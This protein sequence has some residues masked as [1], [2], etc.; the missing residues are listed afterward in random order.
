M[1]KLVSLFILLPFI[2]FSQPMK[3][4]NE[5]EIKLELQKLNTVGSVLYIAAH[6][7]DENTRLLSYLANE[8]KV[9]TA[10]LSL[11][12][13]DGGQNLIGTEQGELLGM[14][15][16]Q[17]LLEA[18]KLDGA[19]QFFTR[20][21]DF[22]FSKNPDETFEKWNKEKI[23]EDVVYIIRKFKPDVI[24]TRFPTTGEGGHGHHTAS[25]ILAVEA[26]DAAADA[27]RFP[28]QVKQ[29]GVWQ[30]KRLVW[31]T[32][33]FS[34]RSTIDSTQLK[35]SIN[36]YNPLLGKSYGELAAEGRTMH[37]SQ[38][39]GSAKN[40][41]Q[42]FEYF[43]HL[44]G[45]EA[46]TDVLEGVNT[47]WSAYQDAKELSNTLAKAYTSYLNGND[48]ETTNNLLLAL[49]QLKN[50]KHSDLAQYKQK[51][52][53]ELLLSIH[54]VWIETLADRS[55][56]AEQDSVNFTTNAIKR[57]ATTTQIKLNKINFSEK[58]TTV[59]NTMLD[60]KQTQF[61]TKIKVKNGDFNLSNP[62]WLNKPIEDGN[63]IFDVSDTGLP[64]KEECLANYELEI[65]GTI[66]NYSNKIFYK[67]IDPV[68]GE[69]Y[70]DVLNL[71]AITFHL[72][73]DLYVFSENK[74]STVKVEVKNNLAEVSGKLK[75]KVP[76][77]FTVFPTEISLDFKNRNQLLLAEFVVT[78]VGKSLNDNAVFSV[79]FTSNSNGIYNQSV[80]EINYKHI[81]NLVRIKS[82][83]AKLISFDVKTIS[84]NIGYIEGAGDDVKESLELLNYTVTELTNDKL[85]TDD[86][87]KYDAIIVG[88]RAYNTHEWLAEHY[89][90]LMKY[91]ENGGNLIV[92]YNT[93]NFISNI[94]SDLGPYPF[95]ITRERVTIETAPMRFLDANHPI[96]NTP[97]KISDVDFNNWVQERGIYF[98]SD[99]EKNYTPIFACN[100]P[101]EKEQSGSLIVC[102]YGKGHFMYT[103]LAFFRQLPAGVPGAYRLF[104]NC[105]EYGKK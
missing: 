33:N 62:F 11:T 90:K 65:N 76:A 98:A 48:I 8:R 1:N 30:A 14:I 91:V 24:I 105:I 51:K 9:R 53:V 75:L 102:D 97:N 85:K 38:G 103:G 41:N 6:P 67:T 81:K 101:N 72:A 21:Y 70:K 47:Q 46:K 7:D 73:S 12:R 15:R 86:L 4:L 23:L 56:F 83:Q 54:G 45:D 32:F 27:K 18:R 37:K 60:A 57:I 78:K 66:V 99:F 44:K 69:L 28:N 77:G 94:K 52:I 92:Q 89:T 55:S 96:L 35:M 19:E 31:N 59:S 49:K 3:Q 87:T 68:D 40:R 34:G 42:I 43:K 22:G 50:V 20:A 63:F 16:T 58:Y 100:D 64:E 13:G 5:S 36:N 104:V 29:L 93:N 10:Y 61:A 26:F 17:E 39:F 82:A 84:K 95:K 74:T 2:G 25:A 88:I 80:R 71:P 79:E